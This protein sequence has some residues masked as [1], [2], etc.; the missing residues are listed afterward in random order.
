MHQTCALKESLNQQ[1]HIENERFHRQI[2]IN[3]FAASYLRESK[4]VWTNRNDN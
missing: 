3:L 4:T 2:F 1:E